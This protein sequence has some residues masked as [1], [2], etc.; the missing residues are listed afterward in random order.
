MVYET[1]SL[2]AGKTHLEQMKK[3]SCKEE[4]F[5]C[6]EFGAVDRTHN[7]IQFPALKQIHKNIIITLGSTTHSTA[8]EAQIKGVV[9]FFNVIFRGYIVWE[10]IEMI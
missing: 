2:L 6:I 3:K 7:W 1:C 8:S 9:A 4:L 5:T 10:C